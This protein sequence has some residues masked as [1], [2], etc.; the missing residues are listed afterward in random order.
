MSEQE[1][2]LQFVVFDLAGVSYGMHI[3]RIGDVNRTTSVSVMTL[4]TEATAFDG[5][6]VGRQAPLADI[7]ERLGLKKMSE[8]RVVFVETGGEMKGYVV[9]QPSEVLR[10]ILAHRVA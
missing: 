6:S 2:E 7:R 8:T 4:P 3:H 10:S 9:D 1:G 5:A